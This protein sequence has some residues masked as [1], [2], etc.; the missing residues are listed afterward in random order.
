MNKIEYYKASILFSIIPAILCLIIF[1]CEDSIDDN[2]EGSYISY[3]RQDLEAVEFLKNKYN[4]TDNRVEWSP[5]VYNDSLI[6]RVTELELD[7]LEIDTF[8]DMICNLDY[9]ILLNLGRN[10]IAEL[11]DCI[12]QMVSLQELYLSRNN[13]VTLPEDFGN[14]INLTRC[15][16]T[17]NLLNS[18]PNSICNINDNMTNGVEVYMNKLC[19]ESQ[20]PDCINVRTQDCD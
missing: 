7:E 10:N 11:P 8:P 15:H 4:I 5:I 18:L 6:F 16:I 14:L 9:L 3:A 2:V 20:Y 19:D 13:L 1:A 12:T 17:F